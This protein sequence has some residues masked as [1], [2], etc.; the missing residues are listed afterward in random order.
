[1]HMARQ[2]SATTRPPLDQSFDLDHPARPLAAA[3]LHIVLQ[4]LR[5][6]L[7][8]ARSAGQASEAEQ[9]R[10]TILQ[11]AMQRHRQHLQAQQVGVERLVACEGRRG[12]QQRLQA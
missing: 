5:H 4:L 1:M 7:L 2:H 8:C 6:A 11:L 12:M 9:Q 10:A 3:P